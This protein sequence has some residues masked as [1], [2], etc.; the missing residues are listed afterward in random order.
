M[1]FYFSHS[2]PWAYHITKDGLDYVPMAAFQKLLSH[3]S[4]I[5]LFVYFSV[6]LLSSTWEKLIYKLTGSIAHT[7]TIGILGVIK[8]AIQQ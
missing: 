8:R 4:L 7:A 2:L 6:E 5:K 1:A 3:F